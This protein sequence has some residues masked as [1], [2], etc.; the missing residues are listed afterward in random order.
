MNMMIGFC[1]SEEVWKNKLK[2]VEILINIKTMVKMLVDVGF[3]IDDV[4]SGIDAQK[5]VAVKEYDLILMDIQ[6]I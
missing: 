3:M 4:C 2:L 1:L 6:S 5:H